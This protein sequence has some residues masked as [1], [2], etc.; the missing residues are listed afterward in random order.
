MG[1]GSLVTFK[2]VNGV[3][4]VISILF[5]AHSTNNLA[6]ADAGAFLWYKKNPPERGLKLCKLRD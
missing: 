5:A 2:R 6:L 3:Q 4:D 1:L